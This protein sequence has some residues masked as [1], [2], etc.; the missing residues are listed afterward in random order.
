MSKLKMNLLFTILCI[1]I[2]TAVFAGA[3][4]IRIATTLANTYKDLQ[5]EWNDQVGTIYSDLSF[6]KRSETGYDLYVP[7][8][9]P[10]KVKPNYSLILYIHGGSFTAGDKKDGAQWAKYFASKGYVAASMNYTLATQTQASNL[11]LMNEQ[12]R[13]C[14]VAIQK[15]SRELGYPVNEM[16]VTGA[17]AGSALALLYAYKEA[18]TS[19]IPVKFVFEQTGPV[20]FEPEGFG[21]Y[22]DKGKAEFASA[23]TGHNISINMVQNGEYRKYVNE[24]SPV[25]YVNE[26]TIPTLLAY[27]PKDKIVPVGLKFQLLDAL[28]KHHVTH[29]YIEYPNSN[30]GMY[31]DP[32][33]QR[34]YIDKIHQ[35][36]QNYFTNVNNNVKSIRRPSL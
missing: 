11:N 1:V 3:G 29:D 7:A 5:V 12:I 17:S 15:K 14:V 6:D 34:E 13:S 28:N 25:H 36:C 18:D 20:A 31:S 35:Y 24:I 30:H 26:H 16:A 27:G 22:D 9:D 23:M 4:Y 19:P 2:F 10:T 32:D 33:K 21:I 8:K